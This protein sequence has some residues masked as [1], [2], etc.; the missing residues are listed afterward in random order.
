MII[1]TEVI[2]SRTLTPSTHGIRLV[3]PPGFAFKPVQFCGVEFMTI[4][5]SEEYPM[6][7]ACSPTRDHLEFGARIVSG[8][9]WKRAFAALKPGDEVEIDGPYGHFVLD[10]A[11]DAVFVAGGIGITPLKGMVEY[12]AD[13][14]S[15]RE[16][17]LIYSNRTQEEIVYREELEALERALPHFRIL[18]TLTQEPA[19]SDWR[20]RRGRM[21]IAM[22]REAAR[23]LR[24]PT[25][26]LCGAP[27]MVRAA[28]E[29][30]AVTG[31]PT[32]RVLYELFSGYG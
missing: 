29:T 4:E 31:V 25:W 32:E 27:G 13:T 20:G 2:E 5:G 15:Q 23:G 10:E 14:C 30:L 11:R 22:L 21:D 26:Y 9:A 24:D 28:F 16:A 19:S 12:L 17:R 7:L 1:R 8:S 6:S 18:H 3:K